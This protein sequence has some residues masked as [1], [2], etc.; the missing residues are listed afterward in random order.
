MGFS[1]GQ[2]IF[3]AQAEAELSQ[4]LAQIQLS[5]LSHVKVPLTSN[6]LGA[7]TSLV[8]NTGSALLTRSTRL[9]RLRD[10]S[11]EKSAFEAILFV[12]RRSL[13]ARSRAFFI[14]NLPRRDYDFVF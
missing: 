4:E 5:V 1:R 8:Y 9:G 6:Q 3:P 13:K 7:L 14:I 2:S 10:R 12:M 11:D